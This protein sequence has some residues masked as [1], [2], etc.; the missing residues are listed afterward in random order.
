MGKG[1]LTIILLIVSKTVMEEFCQTYFLYTLSSVAKR[2]IALKAFCKAL[3]I[4]T[5]KHKMKF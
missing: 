5:K 2:L 4:K 1:I 3:N